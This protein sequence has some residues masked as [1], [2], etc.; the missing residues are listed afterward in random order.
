[1]FLIELGLSLVGRIDHTWFSFWH[2]FQVDEDGVL[3]LPEFEQTEINRLI[4][5]IYKNLGRDR[6]EISA[7]FNLVRNSNYLVEWTSSEE[8]LGL[9][10]WPSWVR[11]WQLQLPHQK[12]IISGGMFHKE[13]FF[14]FPYLALTLVSLLDGVA[15]NYRFLV[16]LDVQE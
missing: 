11:I 16:Y 10:I 13:S 3:F 1:M 5:D 15:R 12:E 7:D 6:V 4:H 14:Y 8:T 9:S 2:H